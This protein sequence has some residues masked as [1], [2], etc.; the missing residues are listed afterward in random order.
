[1]ADMHPVYEAWSLQKRND[2]ETNKE[3]GFKLGML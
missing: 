2:N 1:M 3:P